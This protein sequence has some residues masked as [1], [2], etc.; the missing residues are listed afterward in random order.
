MTS[1]ATDWTHRAAALAAAL[2]D[3]G[4]IRDPTWAAAIA[5]TPRHLLVPRA[6]QQQPDG[7]WT[8]VDTSSEAGL[9]LAYSTTTLVTELDPAGRTVSSSTKPDLMVRMLETL[10]VKPNH[11]VLEIGTGTGYNAALLAHHVGDDRVFSVDVDADLVEVARQRLAAIGSHPGLDARDG[12]DGWPER[13]PFNRIIAT[14]SVPRV[15]WSWAEQLTIGGRVL[16]D[17]KLGPA[18]G[19]L[20]LLRRLGDWLEGR[21]T[22]RWAAFMDMRHHGD[23]PVRRAEKAGVGRERVTVTPAQPWN[24]HRE[25]WFLACLSLPA[26]V[27]YGYVLDEVSR[28][29]AMA[30]LSTPDGSW[31]EVDLVATD[32]ARHVR[33]GGPAALWEPVERAFALWDQW[34]RPDWNRL[35]VTVTP[36]H[37]DIWLDEPKVVI[38]SMSS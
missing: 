7:S 35:G 1:T 29:P 13:A 6:Y 25:V 30:T 34:D 24:S 21:F 32:G 38:S 16:V 27:R 18:A 22:S 3:S 28:A 10:S 11:R 2:I 23:S 17:L 33:E 14:C 37:Q 4:D 19:N 20:V 31:C 9:E 36:T 5:A 15:P 8:E 12:V 26:D